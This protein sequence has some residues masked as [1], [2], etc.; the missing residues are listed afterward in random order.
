MEAEGACAERGSSELSSLVEL[1]VELLEEEGEEED[2]SC[3]R[4]RVMEGL[5]GGE[6]DRGSLEVSLRRGRGGEPRERLA[7][8]ARQA[9]KS[10]EAERLRSARKMESAEDWRW[11]EGLGAVGQSGEFRLT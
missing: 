5:V 3:R 9:D 7:E 4:R 6:G 8:L 1:E 10:E 11:G 2:M